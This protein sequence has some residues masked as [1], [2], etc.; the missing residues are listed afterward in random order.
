MHLGMGVS[1]VR[2]GMNYEPVIAWPTVRNL[3]TVMAGATAVSLP[4][5]IEGA[6]ADI[7][8]YGFVVPNGEHMIT[9]WRD[10]E[11]GTVGAGVPVT[12]TIAGFAGQRAIGVDVLNGFEQRL[13]TSDKG[14]NLVIRDLLAKDYPIILRLNS[15]KVVFLPIV[16]K[17][18]SR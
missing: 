10:V 18:H 7:K 4:V 6:A 3:C 17:G 14:G 8:Q 9:L 2:L 12:M 15:T 1:I 13:I 11:P 16:F 5:T